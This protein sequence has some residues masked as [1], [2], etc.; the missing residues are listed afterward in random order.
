MIHD[1]VEAAVHAQPLPAAT[2]TLFAPPDAGIDAPDALRE[3]VHA[4]GGAGDGGGGAGAGGGGSGGGGAGGGGTGEAGG[5]TATGGVAASAIVTDSPATI[6][7]AVR[8]AGPP[9]ATTARVTV[10]A[11][12]PVFP[13]VTAIQSACDTAVQ[14]HPARVSTETATVPPSAD[15]VV[16]AGVTANL[17]G[18]ASCVTTM[19]TSFTSTLECR[20]AGSRFAATV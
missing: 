3:N 6:T 11:P 12:F 2:E 20:V 18:A 5:G 19:E 15:T 8:D 17:H 16:L 14:L 4:G 7:A 13:F 10:P 1:A 9:F